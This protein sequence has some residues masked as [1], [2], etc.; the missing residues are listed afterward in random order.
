MS[1]DTSTK[2]LGDVGKRSRGRN[3]VGE[4]QSPTKRWRFSF[5]KTHDDET[6]EKSGSNSNLSTMVSDS[7][8]IDSAIVEEDT[9][10][11]VERNVE[12]KFHVE[13]PNFFKAALNRAFGRTTQDG[14]KR[15]STVAPARTDRSKKAP[16]L[17]KSSRTSSSRSGTSLSSRRS[18]PRNADAD[19]FRALFQ[20]PPPP[21]V[22]A[23]P[24]AHATTLVNA[25]DKTGFATTLAPSTSLFE[26]LAD[27]LSG[28]SGKADQV[29]QQVI[30]EVK[31]FGVSEQKWAESIK[32]SLKT[33][34]LQLP[35]TKPRP[36]EPLAQREANLA[37]YLQR[38]E[39]SS[40]RGDATCLLA[41][42]R[43]AGCRVR[44]HVVTAANGLHSFDIEP[45]QGTAPRRT[46]HIGW[47]RR[48]SDEPGRDHYVSIY[49]RRLSAGPVGVSM[50]LEEEE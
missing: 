14:R 24:S 48:G 32:G 17:A 19:V 7:N 47:Y 16:A 23:Q 28:V 29:K 9:G 13:K 49:P 27:Q 37:L 31:K 45:H 44:V 50:I 5:S 15:K 4:G 35:A 30:D 1:L 8:I 41:F 42:A 11:Q 21:I 38:L 34:A 43:I 33:R 20:S 12:K 39:S 2:T 46:K 25:L 26:V 10:K 18:E 3:S 40:F 22:T 36:V 6:G